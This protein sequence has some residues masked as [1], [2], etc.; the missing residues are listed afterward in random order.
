MD[1]LNLFF[2]AEDDIRYLKQTCEAVQRIGGQN[3]N[4]KEAEAVQ[5]LECLGL[6]SIEGKDMELLFQILDKAD[7]VNFSSPGKE[8]SPVRITLGF[9]V[10]EP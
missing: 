1:K 9:R 2:Q 7:R 8:V 3:P 5:W 6:P 4:R 10:W